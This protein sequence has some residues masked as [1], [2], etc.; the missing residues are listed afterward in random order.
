MASKSSKVASL[1]LFPALLAV[2]ACDEE[3]FDDPGSSPR[4]IIKVN[5][6]TESTGTFSSGGN[7]PDGVEPVPWPL[8]NV[9]MEDIMR[10]SDAVLGAAFASTEEAAAQCESTCAEVRA[11]WDG[12]TYAEG[13]YDFG[14]AEI[15]EGEGGALRYRVDVSFLVGYGCNCQQ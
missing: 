12:S 9:L 4:A 14:K 7:W 6:K 13:E 2:S 8:P 1:F 3:S 10:N 11:E 15:F 5:I